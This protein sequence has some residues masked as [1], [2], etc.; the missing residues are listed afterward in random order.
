MCCGKRI[1]LAMRFF[2]FSSSSSSS[3]LDL[4]PSSM[5][6]PA[7]GKQMSVATD[8]PID[9]LLILQDARQTTI[10]TAKIFGS[11]RNS[12]PSL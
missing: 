12:I 1:R 11:K 2:P 6:G 10:A 8:A 9:P 4:N 3:E 7:I 5:S